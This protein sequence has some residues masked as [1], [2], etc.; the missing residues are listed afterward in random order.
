M[1]QLVKFLPCQQ[2]DLGLIPRTHVTKLSMVQHVFNS[3]APRCRDW[4]CWPIS[5]HYLVSSRPVRDPIK[6]IKQT[7]RVG[8]NGGTN[9]QRRR[10][11]DLCEFKASLVY[12]ASTRTGSKATQRNPVLKNHKKTGIAQ[13]TILCPYIQ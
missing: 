6:N 4:V 9:T 12:R 2:K 11:V 7:P 8:W 3:P 13:G 5:L 10:Q 1:A